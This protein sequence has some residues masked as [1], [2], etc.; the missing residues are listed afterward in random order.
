M[1]L[2]LFDENSWDIDEVDKETTK[3][4]LN[5]YIPE[6]VFECLFNHYTEPSSK[7]KDGE[8]KLYR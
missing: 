8:L 5:D 7:T 6:P 4:Y 2:D 1:M 3:E